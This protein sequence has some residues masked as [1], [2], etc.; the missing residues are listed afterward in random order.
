ME[1]RPL[2]EYNVCRIAR[3][4][5]GMTQERWAEALDLSVEAVGQYEAGKILPSDVVVLR[6]IEVSG[7]TAIGYWHLLNKS[8]VARELLPEVERLPLSQAAIRLLLEIREFDRKKRAEELLR[9]AADGIVDPEER[10]EFEV[11][12]RE[13]Q[14]IIRAAMEVQMSEEEAP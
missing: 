9:I 12:V 14:G 8:R 13:L 2:N 6:M 10:A 5:A 11:I 4:T 7:H 1:A 3:K